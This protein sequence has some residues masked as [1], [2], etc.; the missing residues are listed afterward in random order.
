MKQ[1]NVGGRLGEQKNKKYSFTNKQHPEAVT[2]KFQTALGI[3]L[4]ALVVTVVVYY[5]KDRKCSNNNSF[6]LVNN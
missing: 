2:Y 1:K 3:T 5:V 4:V 6:S